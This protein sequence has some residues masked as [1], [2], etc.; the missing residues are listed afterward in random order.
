MKGSDTTPTGTRQ[1]HNLINVYLV[2]NIQCHLHALYIHWYMSFGN[3]YFNRDHAAVTHM[4]I[5]QVNMK[6][7]F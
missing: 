3:A 5:S 6:R 2:N 1:K 4:A 7:Q